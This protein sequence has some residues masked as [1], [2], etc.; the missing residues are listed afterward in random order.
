MLKKTITKNQRNWDTKLKF[1]LWANRVTPKH[2]TRKSPFELVYGKAAIFPIQLAMPITKLSQEVEE[3]P[4]VITRRI[5]Q[6]VEI[7]ENREPVGKNWP[8]IS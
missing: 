3:E 8:I 6:L 2:S 7:N 4:N 5:N 1:T